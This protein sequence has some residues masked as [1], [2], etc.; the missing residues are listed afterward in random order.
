MW[1]A[2]GADYDDEI[3]EKFLNLHNQVFNGQLETW[4]NNSYSLLALIILLDQFSRYI[5]RNTAQAFAQDE[6]VV[7]IV[8]QGIETGWYQK[9][10]FIQRKF[11]Y[12]PLMQAENI[13]T[14]ELSVTMFARLHDEVPDELKELF[15]KSLSFAES[16]YYVISKFGR[17]PELNEILDRQSSPSEIEFLK[18][19][20]YRFL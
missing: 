13:E 12:M 8:K 15:S 19:G 11:F 17:F 10:Y 5:C 2:N 9:L 7:R 6:K 4:R 18:R 14:Q 16:H 20:K 3:R 1:F